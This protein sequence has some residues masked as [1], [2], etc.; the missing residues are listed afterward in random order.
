VGDLTRYRQKRDFQSTA[1]PAGI[2]QADPGRG[3]DQLSFVVQEHHARRLHWDFRLERDGVLVSWAVPRGI[4]PDP[5]RNHLAVHVEDHPLEYG[6]FEGEIPAGGYGAGQVSIWDRGTYET[7][8]WELDGKK[9]EVMIT[10]HGQHVQ[11][12]YVLFQTDGKNWMMH[13]MDPPQ[14][15]DFEPVPDKVVPMLAKLAAGLQ[16]PDDAWA[17]EFKWDGIR[18]VAFI[19]GGRLRLVTRNQEEV[20]ARYPELRALAEAQSG[21]A[22]V[23]DG[24]V[25]ALGENGAPS[26]ERLQQRMGLT[27]PAQ[28]KRKQADVP[29]AYL[30]F[31][32]L[33]LDG[34]NLMRKPYRERRRRLQDLKLAGPTWQV[35]EHQ[36]GGGNTLLAASNRL[37]LEGVMAKKLDSAY[38]AGKRSG[39]W[40]KIKN[41]WRQELVIAGWMPGEGRRAGGIGSLLVGYWEGDRFVYAGKVGTGFTDQTLDRLEAL[42]EPLARHSSPFQTGRPPRAA[43]FVDPALVGEFEFAEWT[44]SALPPSRASARTRIRAAWCGRG[45]PVDLSARLVSRPTARRPAFQVAGG[46]RGP[47]EVDDFAG[48]NRGPHEVQDFVGW[49]GGLAQRGAQ[50]GMADEACRTFRRLH[51]RAKRARPSGAADASASG[52]TV[53]L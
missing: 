43:R 9:K 15:S 53:R 41:H 42:L 37:G 28:I 20:T 39:F 34:E 36:V 29:V 23:L 5:K 47:H 35:P 22:M 44:S 1:E 38:D 19:D 40:L 46:N 31:D 26:F 8:K 7:H 6:G 49:E 18:A 33:Y 50:S 25:V 45:R 21:R 4:P 48:W 11:G 32:L 3:E 51:Q 24:E 12:R 17:Y 52:G 30:V 10:L 2:R 16:S 13:R 27:A 14:K